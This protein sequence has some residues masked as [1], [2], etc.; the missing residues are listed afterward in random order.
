MVLFF[1]SMFNCVWNGNGNEEFKLTHFES[2]KKT[3]DKQFLFCCC[4]IKNIAN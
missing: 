4:K 1:V 3:S 2:T